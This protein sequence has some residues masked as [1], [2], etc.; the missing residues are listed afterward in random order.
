M[1]HMLVFLTHIN[2]YD[3]VRFL[4]MF[5]SIVPLEMA[6]SILLWESLTM[7]DE[8]ESYVVCP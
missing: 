8:D 4:R 2:I 7:D 3:F 6:K 5:Q 1:Q